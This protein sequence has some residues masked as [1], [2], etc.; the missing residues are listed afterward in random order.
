MATPTRDTVRDERIV[1]FA[2]LAHKM[3]SNP[4]VQHWSLDQ[5]DL[6]QEA[7]LAIIKAVDGWDRS[8]DSKTSL[9]Q[10]V[11]FC[12][13]RALWRAAKRAVK[14]AANRDEFDLSTLT[15]N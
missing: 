4:T 14:A 10:Y 6:V 11:Q 2:H 7:M 13:R 12:I 9:K 3:A 15:A 1:M 5:A 8:H